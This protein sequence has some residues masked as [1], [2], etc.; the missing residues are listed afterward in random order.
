MPIRKHLGA[1]KKY[2]SINIKNIKYSSQYTAPTSTGTAPT[3]LS[4]PSYCDI[5]VEGN[6]E[7]LGLHISQS[8]RTKVPGNRNSYET[9]GKSSRTHC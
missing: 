1:L 8:S 7:Y 2:L 3:S 5:L 9:E 4:H 6:S